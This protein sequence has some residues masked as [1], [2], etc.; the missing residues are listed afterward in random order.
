LVE[1]PVG[2]CRV[3]IPL[4][5]ICHMKHMIISCALVACAGM[6]WAQGHAKRVS[7]AI[8][9]KAHEYPSAHIELTWADD[10]SATKWSIYRQPD[11]GDFEL[12]AT[13]QSPDTTYTDFSV[14]KGMAYTYLIH[15]E[16]VT[17]VLGFGLI[18]AGIGVAPNHHLG[19]CL[20][21][22]E[23]SL[24]T[25]LGQVVVDYTKDLEREGW[26]VMTI[27]EKSGASVT[28]LK[29]VIQ[30][31][32]TQSDSSITHLVLIGR[33]AV[34]YS[35]YMAPDGHTALTSPDRDHQGAWPSDAYYGDLDG[36]W[37]DELDLA[38]NKPERNLNLNRKGDG[39]FDHNVLPGKVELAVGRIYLEKFNQ[40]YGRR[41][42]FYRR[43]FAQLH[44]HRSGALRWSEQALVNNGFPKEYEGFAGVGFR[45]FSPMV[46]QAGLVRGSLLEHANSTSFLASY[47]CGPGDYHKCGFPL[48]NASGQKVDSFSVGQTRDFFRHEIRSCVNLLFGSYFGDWD[49]RDNLL[50]APLAGLSPSL[51]TIW[52]GRPVVHLHGMALGQTIGQS[53]LVTQ[54]V[55]INL[56]SFIETMGITHERMTHLALM[57][58]PTL[59]LRY[60]PAL[61][62]VLLTANEPRDRV[63][64]SWDTTGM[65]GARYALWHKPNHPDSLHWY[66]LTDSAIADDHFENVRPLAGSSV[67]RVMPVQWHQGFSGSYGVRGLWA[68]DTIHHIKK[69]VGMPGAKDWGLAMYPNPA[70]DRVQ[71]KIN[72]H[73]LRHLALYGADGR[74]FEV[75]Y[76][77]TNEGAVFH[78][79]HLES[80]A[81]VVVLALDNGRQWKRLLMIEQDR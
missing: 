75:N 77:L 60:A 42:D 49:S 16:D 32:Y 20:V 78:L 9:A 15:K 74:R 43:Y 53:L 37:T 4:S 68:C 7:V 63:R 13:V 56:F 6:A 57:G 5:L 54:N 59:R 3:A 67:Y 66:A 33:L 31:A 19:T 39:K 17:S 52:A 22:W 50:R 36:I 28:R 58:D 34:P 70:S 62:Q 55:D 48:R 80:G 35:G 51:A 61:D 72:G 38:L 24:A 71:V 2:F 29:A 69:P 41:E 79:G 40:V 18:M 81:Y 10:W 65:A 25:A 8:E 73:R 21:I 44:A 12:L 27:K 11:S 23:D 14:K 1:Y 46:G 45:S 47:G 26:N 64:V 76:T 30:D